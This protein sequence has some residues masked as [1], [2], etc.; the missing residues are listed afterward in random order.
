MK[1]ARLVAF[2]SA[3][4]AGALALSTVQAQEMSTAR[5]SGAD[6]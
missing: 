4:L 2:L 3:S 5:T 6:G 1:Q